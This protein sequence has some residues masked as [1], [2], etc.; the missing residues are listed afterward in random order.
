MATSEQSRRKEELGALEVGLLMYGISIA[1]T[2]IPHEHHCNATRIVSM[3]TSKRYIDRNRI[4]TKGSVGRREWR[5]IVSIEC[6]KPL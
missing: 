5:G 3:Q 4:R 1:V 2:T 6:A